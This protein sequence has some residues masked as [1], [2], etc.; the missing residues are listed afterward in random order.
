[1]VNIIKQYI[2]IYITNYKDMFVYKRIH[3][4][5]LNIY[6]YVCVRARV[7]SCV[8]TYMCVIIRLWF[9]NI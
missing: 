3:S 6:I 5:Y 4:V 1:M 9:C 2:Y 8:C 7:Y